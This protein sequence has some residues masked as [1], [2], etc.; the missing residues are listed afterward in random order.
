MNNR[1][2]RK[3]YVAQQEQMIDELS[4]LYTVLVHADTPENCN[5]AHVGDI[6]RVMADLRN[7]TQYVI[8]AV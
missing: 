4:K 3:A 6:A 2:A 8:P 1:E 7:I 5:W